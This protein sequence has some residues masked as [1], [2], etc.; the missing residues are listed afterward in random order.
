VKRGGRETILLLTVSE[1]FRLNEV[2]D[3]LMPPQRRA[4]AITGSQAFVRRNGWATTYCGA[5]GRNFG[6]VKANDRT[7][8]QTMRASRK[9]IN[10]ATIGDG[11]AFTLDGAGSRRIRTGSTGGTAR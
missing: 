1:R 11:K 5:A 6:R 4:Q 9:I 2:W 3:D 8:D 10:V 7:D